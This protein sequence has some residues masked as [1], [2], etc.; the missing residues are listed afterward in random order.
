MKFF[1]DLYMG[2]MV[3]SKYEAIMKK[4][5]SDKPVLDLYLITMANNPDNMLEIVPQREVLQKGYPNMDIRV[6]GL[7]KGKKEAIVVV[8]SIVEESLRETGSAD[9]RVFLNQRWEEQV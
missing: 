6:V 9:V 4:L 8:Q 5:N 3:S 7:A 2:D 1:H